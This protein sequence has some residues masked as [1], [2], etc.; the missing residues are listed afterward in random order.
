[1][2]SFSAAPALPHH[3]T[4]PAWRRKVHSGV[5]VMRQHPSLRELTRA[6]LAG[7]P[8]EDFAPPA[9]AAGPAATRAPARGRRQAPG[10]GLDFQHPGQAV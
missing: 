1:M 6:A 10:G 2:P 3:G 4:R 5:K 7:V 9:A 8:P